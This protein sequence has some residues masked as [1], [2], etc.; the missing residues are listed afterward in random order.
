MNKISGLTEKE[1]EAIWSLWE[2]IA[3]SDPDIVKLYLEELR[4][5]AHILKFDRERFLEETGHEPMSE[6]DF[7]SKIYEL[8]D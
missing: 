3:H 4:I 2:R 1:L 7:F 6:D 8:E 5:V